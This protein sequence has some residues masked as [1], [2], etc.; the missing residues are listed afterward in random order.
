MK[1]SAKNIILSI[2]GV[3]LLAVATFVFLLGWQG[4]TDKIV[5]VAD[6][7]QADPSWT[8]RSERITP[9]KLA[10]IGDTPCPSLRRHWQTD[11][12]LSKKKL[13]SILTESSYNFPIKESCDSTGSKYDIE[14]C[15]AIGTVRGFEVKVLIGYVGDGSNKG[16]VTLNIEKGQQ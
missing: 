3:I 8:L 1:K 14:T 4:S 7:F 12:P 6:Q 10:C 2:I 16:L 15:K 5:S 11:R 13:Q 9:P